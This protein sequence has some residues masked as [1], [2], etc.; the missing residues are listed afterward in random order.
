VASLQWIVSAY[1]IAFAA[2]IL[3]AGAL[4]DRIGA[5]RVFAVGFALF[6]AASI[7]CGL[8][9]SLGMLVA[10]RA[11]QGAAAAALVPGSLTLLTHDHP[12]PAS[13]SRAIGVWAAAG[14]VA[15]SAGPVVGGSLVAALGW[16]AIFF[17]NVPIGVAGVVLTLVASRET[18]RT[19]RR[20]D[21]AGQALAVLCLGIASAAI[22][23]SGRGGLGWTAVALGLVAAGVL[24]TVF[25]LVERRSASPM[26][27]VDL[28]RRRAF[29]A[30]TAIG[31][32]VNTAF[33]G[34]IFVL[35][36][37]FQEAR[38]LTPFLTG[39][40]FAPMTFAVL[41]ANLLAGRLTARYGSRATVLAG[42]ALSAL[43]LAGTALVGPATAYPLVA[44]PLVVLG[45]G[46]GVVVPAITAAQLGA[47]EATRSGVAS[48]TLNAARQT[49]S[50]LGVA[51]M[52]AIA[53]A[54]GVAGGLRVDALVGL[55]LAAGVAAIA[56]ALD[57]RPAGPRGPVS[58][59]ERRDPVG[60]MRDGPAGSSSRMNSHRGFGSTMGRDT[61]RTR[62]LA[63]ATAIA[64]EANT[65]VS[66]QVAEEWS[67]L[68]TP[69][70]RIG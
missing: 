52:G 56:L 59:P 30:A 32:L 69:D 38:G 10:A 4:G 3:S 39:L 43:G 21:P 58:S 11:V 13:R 68:S 15:L 6:T 44:A 63:S 66:S 35:S 9:P 23:E 67:F 54:A 51:I 65:I 57:G 19:R 5:R 36:L 50:V 34:L 37:F 1:T 46:L 8:A 25:V 48:G 62:G 47:V 61:R 12:D 70:S 18:P 24:A 33:Y 60:S 42:A 55:G 29:S 27:P 28:F 20:F 49:G 45:A 64:I 53:G 17:V 16:R 2:L 41:I 31:V 26:L 14:A 22:I 7:A 40:A